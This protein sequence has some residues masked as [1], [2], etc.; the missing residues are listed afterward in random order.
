MT[1]TCYYDD[2][3]ALVGPGPLSESEKELVEDV[4]FRVIWVELAHE[5]EHDL[6]RYTHQQALL[7]TVPG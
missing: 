5:D 2:A 7:V 3:L 1:D 6:E 4:E